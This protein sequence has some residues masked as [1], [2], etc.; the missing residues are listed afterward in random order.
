MW[1]PEV[2]YNLLTFWGTCCLHLQSVNLYQTIWYHIPEGRHLVRTSDLTT[3][4]NLFF[5]SLSW[6]WDWVH[7]VLQPLFGL[8]YQPQMIDD[9][10]GAISGMQIGRRNQSAQ[11]KPAPVPPCPPQIPHD[12]TCAWT[13]AA[14]VGSQRLIARAM[15]RLKKSVSSHRAKPLLQLQ[16]K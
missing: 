15:A 3:W 2:W 9:D 14:A 12:L 16:K 13:Q 1:H 4:R 6:G 8:L 10:R 5:F 7:L 11:R